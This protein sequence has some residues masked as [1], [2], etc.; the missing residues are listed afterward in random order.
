M[1]KN[2]K[3]AMFRKCVTFQ[4]LHDKRLYKHFLLIIS[5]LQKCITQ[6]KKNV[7]QKIVNS[8]YIFHAVHAFQC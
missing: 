3:H 5:K 7:I 8:L 4:I 6:F 1:F 2:E